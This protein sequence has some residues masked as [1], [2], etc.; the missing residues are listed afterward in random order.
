MRLGINLMAWSGT[1][2]P[3]ELALFPRIA[4]L[5]YDGVELPI[6]VPQTVVAAEVR[7]VLEGNRLACTV[8][9]ALPR[10][11]SLLDPGEQQAGVAFLDRCAA[12]AAAC[13]AQIVCGPIYAPVGLLPGRPR[14]REEWEHGVQGLRAA[15]ECAARHGVVLAV[16]LLNRFETHFLNTV[17]DGIAFVEAVGHPSVRLHLDTFHLNI[18]EKDIPAAIARAGKH[19][20][21]VHAAENDRGS[22]GSGHV[23]WTGVRDALQGTGYDGWVVAETFT[24][25]IP[26]IAAATAIWR[27]IVPDGWT[28]ARESIASLRA[29][30]R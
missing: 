24:A 9:T 27:P 11:A 1:T 15:G 26:E 2:G 16:E 19:L 14:T 8:S 13:G 20:Y 22:V 30:F 18:E 28:Y 4:E 23:P 12:T 17:E 7:R 3:Q 21:H 5:G 10:G 29:H 6:F 25:T